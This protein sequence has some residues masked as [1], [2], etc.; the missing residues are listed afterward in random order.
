VDADL[1]S[2]VIYGHKKDRVTFLVRTYCADMVV[3]RV[4]ELGQNPAL[5]VFLRNYAPPSPRAEVLRA[6]LRDAVDAWRHE[7]WDTTVSRYLRSGKAAL[8]GWIEFYDC[9][10]EM[11]QRVDPHKLLAHVLW[12]YCHLY[13]ARRGAAAFLSER[14]DDL[15]DARGALIQAAAEYQREANLLATAYDDSWGGMPDLRRAYFD[16]CH[17]RHNQEWLDTPIDAWDETLRQRERAILAGAL[18]IEGKAVAL[19]EGASGA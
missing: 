13:Q 17:T 9:L 12:N 4:S 15:P 5:A 1:N 19:L 18:A 8:E 6:V 11:A 7:T 3:C 16:R 14:A 10:E 2:A